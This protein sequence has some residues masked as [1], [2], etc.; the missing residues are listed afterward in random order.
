VRH[1]GGWEYF[2]LKGGRRVLRSDKPE[3]LLE[4]NETNM[5]QCGVSSEQLMAELDDLGYRYITTINEGNMAFSAR[6]QS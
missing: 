1:G 5:R 6:S 4:V 2:V 3:L